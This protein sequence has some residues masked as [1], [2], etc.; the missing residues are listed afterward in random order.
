MK[1]I[2]IFFAF[3]ATI[4]P[5]FSQI[6]IKRDS[7]GALIITSTVPQQDG[8]VVTIESAAMDTATVRERLFA[9]LVETYSTIGRLEKEITDLKKQATKLTT[10]SASIDTSTYLNKTRLLYGE[11]IIGVYTWKKSGVVTA[12]EI[13]R[14]TAGAIIA[15]TGTT[16]G[17]VRIYAPNYIEIRNYFQVGTTYV[18]TFFFRVGGRWIGELNGAQI[19][20]RPN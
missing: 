15:K 2:L 18:N 7:T 10:V 4:L 1:Y 9:T 16:T 19:V 14:N 6:G 13:R 11:A 20:L 8:S 17:Q 12:L 5:S 3:F